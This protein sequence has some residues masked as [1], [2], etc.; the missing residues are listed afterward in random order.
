MTIDSPIGRV[1][2]LPG[3]VIACRE[4]DVLVLSDERLAQMHAAAA[5]AGDGLF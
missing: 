3:L 4:F 5:T 2:G 1:R